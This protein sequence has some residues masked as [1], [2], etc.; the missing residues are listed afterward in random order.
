M[1]HFSTD[2]KSKLILL[3]LANRLLARLSSD[4]DS[5]FRGRI[6]S[7]LSCS[8]PLS[9]PSGVNM[10]GAINIDNETYYEDEENST[11][12]EKLEC[13]DSNG[14]EKESFFFLYGFSFLH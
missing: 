9:D 2:K 1:S 7:F 3:R 13:Q 5:L 12:S 10:R 6:L 11:I 8:F 4:T 14:L